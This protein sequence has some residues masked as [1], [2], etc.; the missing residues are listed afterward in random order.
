MKRV[1][2][3]LTALA[4]F[5]AG[6]AAAQTAP[7]DTAATQPAPATPAAPPPVAPPPAPPPPAPAKPAAAA[8]PA[9]YRFGGLS[10]LWTKPQGDFG[11]VAGDG[12]GIT[13]IGEQFVNPTRMIAITSDVGY[14]DFGAKTKGGTRTDFSMFPVQAGLRVYP[15]A[16]KKPDSKAQVFGEG[17]LGFFTTRSEVETNLGAS[18]NYDYYFGF[19]AGAGVKLAA[20]PKVSLLVDATWNWVFA[21]GTDPNY[22]AFRGALMVPVGAR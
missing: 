18:S 14:V 4:L 12:W 3:A 21:T 2:V 1:L 13:I 7:P 10:G 9:A 6:I 17:G 11:D 19:N 16:Q 15:L 20:N 8:A 22:L 5:C